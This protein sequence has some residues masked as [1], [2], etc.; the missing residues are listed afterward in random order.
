VLLPVEEGGRGPEARR[1]AATK[2]QAASRWG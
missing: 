2:V 1:K